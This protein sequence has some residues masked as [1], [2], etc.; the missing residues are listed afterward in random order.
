M[1][2]IRMNL[3][4]TAGLLATTLL[5]APATIHAA[6]VLDGGGFFSAEVLATANESIRN[7]EQKSGHE[8]RIETFANV[9][10]DQVESVAKMDKSQRETFFTKWLHNRAE[11][12]KSR[13]VFVL[14]CKEPS[15]LRLWAG[16]AIQ[17][18]GFGAAQTKTVRETLL[19]GFKAKEYDKTLT[20]VVAQLST[21]FDG[22]SHAAPTHVGHKSVAHNAPAPQ[23]VPL[24][25]MPA[26]EAPASNW[27]SL[28]FVMA[29]VIGGVLLFSIVARM[30]GGRGSYG[31]GGSGGMGGGYGGGGGGFLSGLTGGIFGA[32]AGNWLY[33]QFTDHH[34]SAGETHSTDGNLSTFGDS[35]NTDS[36]FDSSSSDSGG[37]DF[38]GGD[39]GGGDFGGGG[40]DVGGG[41][42]F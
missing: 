10:A 4:L 22:L 7:L 12:T 9:P 40:G 39:F 3:V 21:T 16:T 25:H 37:T 17:R 28:V 26:P 14:I 15:H 34:A 41:G 18:A 6:D 32:L 20:D 24:P 11:A 31:P 1:L 13:G 33:N 30:F 8:I 23:H 42:D 38:G 5:L 2:P 29:L 27:G 19:T 36:G 35:S